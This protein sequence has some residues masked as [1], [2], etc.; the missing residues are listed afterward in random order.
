MDVQTISQRTGLPLRKIRYVLDHRLLPGMRIKT[1]EN[2][3]GH[4]RSFTPLEGFGIAC[5]TTLLVGGVKR[6]ATIDFLDSLCTFSFP[7]TEGSKQKADR[8]TFLEEVWTSP[9]DRSATVLLGDGLN[10]RFTLGDRDS[11]WLQPGTF[12]ELRA[13]HPKITVSLDLADIRGKLRE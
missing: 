7:Q 2:R 11:Q 5:A 10:V 13:F 12:A 8:R 3:H 1:D 9:P 4:P 6:D